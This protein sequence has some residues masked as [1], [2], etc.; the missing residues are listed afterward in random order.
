MGT[1][2]GV[3]VYY[4]PENVFNKEDF[5]A[6]KILVARNDGSG[7]ADELLATETV[8]AI[9]VDGANNKW[10]GTEGSGVYYVSE[11]GTQ[12]LKNFNEDNSA[13][14]SNSI[15]SI[16]IDHQLGNVYFGTGKGII[17]YK[18]LATEGSEEFSNVYVYPNP[19]RPEYTGQ[20]AITGLAQDVNV[21]ITDVGG[22]IVYESY[23]EGGQA[24][25]NGN[26]LSG[27]RVSTGV[28]LVFSSNN[29]GLKTFVSKLLFVN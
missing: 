5:Y 12:L 16:A 11:D 24:V 25:W 18:G 8:T 6:H 7:L 22:N 27:R 17:S 3:V 21:K 14:L 15:T 26:D 13:L 28:Y 9:A 19:V 29:D 23:A 4:N 20:I 2:E 1:A 10:I